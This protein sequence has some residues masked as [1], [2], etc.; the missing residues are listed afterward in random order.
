MSLRLVAF[1]IVAVLYSSTQVFSQDL[2]AASEVVSTPVFTVAAMVEPQT[3][4]MQPCPS[5]ALDITFE[6]TE[7][8]N[9]NY[10]LTIYKQNISAETCYVYTRSGGAWVTPDR[11]PEGSRVKVC[12][13]CETGQP[14]PVTDRVI[15]APGHFAHQ[16]RRWE[17][18]PA[19]AS[20][21]C[22]TATAMTW[23][24]G[25]ANGYIRLSSPSLLKPICSRL[26]AMDYTAAAASPALT[27][28]SRQPVIHW[29]NGADVSYSRERIPLR[30]RV[31]D[32]GHE[33]LL[34]EHSS[35]PRLFLRTPDVRT[36]RGMP[37]NDFFE[38]E[39]QNPTCKI[40]PGG[41]KGKP[42]VYVMEFDSS[43]VIAEDR[44]NSGEF[45]F[46]VSALAGAMGRYS[47]VGT[48]KNFHLSMINGK[49]LV[50]NW[51]PAVEGLA[52]SLILDKD[53]Y[54]VGEEIPLHVALENV[55]SPSLI[56]APN[57]PRWFISVKLMDLENQPVQSTEE[58]LTGNL[59]ACY[60]FF[61]GEITPVTMK[62]SL[63]GFRPKKPG[64]YKVIATWW[65]ARD[66]GCDYATPSALIPVESNLVIFRLI[67]NSNGE[68]VIDDKSPLHK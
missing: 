22:V 42:P 32:P 36:Q 26:T 10:A 65:P 60:H 68:T 31:E 24:G 43:Y 62:L 3:I 44:E 8:P 39:I 57:T 53:T 7:D 14:E 6:G 56:T 18:T 25:E 46:N 27:T 59:A 41:S 1:G 55:S 13:N 51:G 17:T 23:E 19:D 66:T 38:D 15:L 52:A 12:Y 47:L 9:H 20:T 4:P 21:S 2:K 28:A 30:V 45:T 63:Y 29:D 49:V 16:T 5:A 48:T 40:E 67:A 35:C 34:D 33:L 50:R 11:G 37:T 61:C 54:E 64:I 58:P